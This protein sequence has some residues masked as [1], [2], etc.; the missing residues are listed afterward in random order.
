MDALGQA[1]AQMK[2]NEEWLDIER[3]FRLH[4]TRLAQVIARVVRDPARAEELAVEVCLKWSARRI[5]DAENSE[6]WL[7]RA[8]VRSGLNELRHQVRRSRYERV[9]SFVRGSPTPEELLA[10]RQEQE[11]VRL[12]LATIKPREAEL[13]VLR[14]QG[15]T[16]EE[17]AAILHL[18]P[19]SIGT[20]LSRA[21]Q[22]FRKEYTRR[23]GT[24]R[25]GSKT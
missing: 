14:S 7:Y 8:A 5:T 25:L 13:L 24:P 23:Y 15:F 19:A 1:A 17:L 11:R 10:A 9:V 12:L 4:Y 18:N 3:I 2:P 22:T 20:L 21:Q 6:R 16:Y